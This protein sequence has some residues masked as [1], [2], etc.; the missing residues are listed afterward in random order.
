MK[1]LLLTVIA[2]LFAAPLAMAEWTTQEEVDAIT[3]KIT[4]TAFVENQS[5]HE[6]SVYRSDNGDVWGN[7]ALSSSSFDQIHPEKLIV[8]RVDKKKPFD[9]G[10]L[11]SI[12]SDF[13]DAFS[14]RLDLKSGREGAEYVAKEIPQWE[15][16][17]INFRLRSSEDLDEPLNEGQLYEIAQGEK[18]LVR[19]YLSTGGHKD[20][21]FTLKGANAAIAKIIGH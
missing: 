11:L 21:E 9:V 1:R 13:R 19:Y 2:L 15:P 7:F 20:T 12:L 16:K 8:F 17:W 5:G 4:K 18:I 14:A 6:F 3:D 10:K